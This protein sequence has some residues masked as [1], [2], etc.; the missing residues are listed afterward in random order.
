MISNSLKKTPRKNSHSDINRLEILPFLKKNLFTQP[1]RNKTH[2][3]FC[4]YISHLENRYDYMG[5]AAWKDEQ[6]LATRVQ[7]RKSEEQVF[8]FHSQF[9]FPRFVPS[10]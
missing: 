4:P 3:P 8:M 6:V 2:T 7:E 1:N 5:S 9:F 10:E